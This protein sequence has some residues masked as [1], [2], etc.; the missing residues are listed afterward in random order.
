[1]ADYLKI[2]EVAR[3]L[4]VSEPTVRRM[5]KG[6]KLPSVFIGGAYRVSEADLEEFLENARVTPGKAV[7]SPSQRPLFNGGDEERRTQLEV[8]ES[9]IQYA[10]GRAEH[11]DQKLERG[12]T[13]DYATAGKAFVLA[14]DAIDEFS[15]FTGWLF[16]GPARPVWTAL[17]NGVGL[18][19]A[20]EYDA[21]VDTLVER[22]SRTQ[23]M[24]LDNAAHLDDG[25]RVADLDAKRREVAANAAKAERRREAG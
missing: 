13:S 21:L 1:L 6:G 7:A 19:I 17:E 12:R 24:L 15:A 11:Y 8:V 18:E 4:D 20:D 22:I 2:P 25:E 23:R 10:I 3:R 5:V 16:D 14:S 9:C